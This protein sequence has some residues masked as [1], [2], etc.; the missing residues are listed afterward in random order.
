MLDEDISRLV[1]DAALL[2]KMSKA[3]V[4]N[5]ILREVLVEDYNSPEAHRKLDVLEVKV[6]KVLAR[7]E[8]VERVLV[9]RLK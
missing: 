2:A 1:T 8:R 5:E 6:D 3:R 9:G 4:V 7:V